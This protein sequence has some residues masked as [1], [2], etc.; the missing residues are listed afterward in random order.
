MVRARALE[1]AE[2][3]ALTAVD[4]GLELEQRVGRE[5]AFEEAPKLVV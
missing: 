1:H 4:V 5:R 2:V 3:A